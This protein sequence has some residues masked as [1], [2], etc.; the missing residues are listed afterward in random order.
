MRSFWAAVLFVLIAS[1]S[2]K[3]SAPACGAIRDMHLCGKTAG[4]TVRS[5]MLVALPDA[6]R[7]PQLHEY[8]C[9]PSTP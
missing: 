5:S 2:C 4:C 6:A 7:P 9:I 8:D 1:D 3:R